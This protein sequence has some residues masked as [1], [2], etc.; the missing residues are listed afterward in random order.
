MSSSSPPQKEIPEDF[1]SSDGR[2]KFLSF[3]DDEA[4]MSHRENFYERRLHELKDMDIEVGRT[5]DWGFMEKIG[6]KDIFTRLLRREL[7]DE[8][9]GTRFLCNAWDIALNIREPIFVELVQ[10]FLSTFTFKE[11]WVR[12]GDFTSYHCIE[13][14]LCG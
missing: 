1:K 10:E 5:L 2:R 13:F 3:V 8:N 14:R 4:I 7:Q 9:G 11:H 6:M 12:Q